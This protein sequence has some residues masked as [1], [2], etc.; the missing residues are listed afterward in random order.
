M[1]FAIIVLK[2]PTSVLKY[3][4]KYVFKY[5]FLFFVFLFFSVSPALALP[6]INEFLAHSSS[7]TS[8]WV[9]F[10]NLD[11]VD[12]SGYW[13]DDDLSFTE[14]S[15]NTNK[16][17]LATLSSPTQKYAYF[18][19]SANMFNNPGDYVVLFSSSGTL[20]DQYRYTNDPGE[21]VIVGRSPDGADNWV[22]GLTASQGG[23]NPDQ[24]PSPT[25]TPSPTPSPSPSLSPTP[26]PSPSSTPT[27]SP[28]PS[29]K[30]S[31]SPKP[32]PTPIKSGPKPSPSPS[33]IP[34]ISPSPTPQEELVLGV[35]ES[36]TA[37]TPEG[38]ETLLADFVSKKTLLPAG[39]IGIGLVLLV[40]SIYSLFKK[41]SSVRISGEDEES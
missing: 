38:G 7:D 12:L 40:F 10:Y 2:F 4:L 18:V 11:G 9:E 26:S 35:Q 13:I 29:P 34:Q 30:A 33:I 24:V 16:K 17:S 25:P 28:P 27:P 37:A 8:E 15:G 22:I 23:P 14:D 36:S 6:Q 1:A 41:S 21:N 19:L 5:V 31:P 32:S 3:I 20:I 39:L